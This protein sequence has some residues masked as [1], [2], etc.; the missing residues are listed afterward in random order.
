MKKGHEFSWT[1]ARGT[2]T[3][4]NGHIYYQSRTCDYHM[5]LCIEFEEFQPLWIT[6][7]VFHR[8]HQKRV[9]WQKLQKGVTG[10]LKCSNFM[11]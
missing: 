4:P 2:T 3:Q 7:I 8:K 1:V 11:P 6:V 10:D 9:G 5:I